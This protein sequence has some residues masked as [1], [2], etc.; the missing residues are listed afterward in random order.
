MDLSKKSFIITGATGRLGCE[1]VKRL[2]ELGAEVYPVVLK[3]GYQK[4]KRVKWEAKSN[5]IFINNK[6]SLSSV[7]IP[8]YVINFHWKADRSLSFSQQLKYELHN[9]I[10][11]NFFFWEWLS[12]KKITKFINISSVKLFSYLNENPVISTSS[13]KPISP[14]GIAKELSESYFTQLY[15][16]FGVINVRLSSVTSNG[17][18]P[19]HLVNQIYQSAFFN[20]K[21]VVNK[22]HKSNLL[23]IHEA[24]DLII[25]VAL[26]GN[27]LF[28]N[29][30]GKGYLNENIVKKFEKI[31]NKKI[32]ADFINLIPDTNDRIFKFDNNKFHQNFIRRLTI[33]ELLK[34]YIK[35]YK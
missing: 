13:P 2:E 14:Y 10:F 31:S 20:K 34:N 35:N 26:F 7:P 3:N 17:E 11:C 18:H 12:G 4:P 15:K 19:S 28:Y 6:N 16:S 5:P 25:A 27:K 9:S 32:N 1:T 30:G 8:N 22:G 23:H 24:V 21:I 29:L 33:E